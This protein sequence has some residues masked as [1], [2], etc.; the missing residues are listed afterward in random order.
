MKIDLNLFVVFD[1]IYCEGNITKAASVLNLSQPAVSHSLGKL[2]AY[3]DDALFIRQG[4]EMR[5]TPVAKNV[6]ADVREALHQLQ[7]CLVQSR[8][9]EPLTSRKNFSMSLHGSLEPYYLPIL[10]E[11]LAKEAPAIHL[12]S[13]K[14]VRRT[15][16]ENKLASGDIDFAIDALIPVS[17]NILHTQLQ[18]DEL[19]VV[20][21][22]NHPEISDQLNLDTYLKLDHV[23]VSSRS[24]GPGVEDFELSRIGL[25]RNI[26][27]RCQHAL[28]ACRVVMNSNMLLTLHKTAAEM[29]SSMLDINIYPLPVELPSIDVH[30]YWHVNVDKEPANK[31]LRN[32][33]IMAALNTKTQQYK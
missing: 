18:R 3:F 1:A 17:E 9:F 4:N 30:L 25:H 33:M 19:V 11:S 24:T 5:P 6:I 8:Q 28:S 26:S 13:I 20:S 27:L 7:V 10:Q 21:R 14:R 23:L 16:L 15:E 31:W 32:K 22:K 2:R 29:Y 12:R